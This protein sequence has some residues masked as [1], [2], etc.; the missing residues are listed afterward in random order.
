MRA[1]VV[2]VSALLD[3]DALSPSDLDLTCS[4]LAL[5]FS[6]VGEMKVAVNGI[7]IGKRIVAATLSL[8][9]SE[10][11]SSTHSQQPVT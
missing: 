6:L 4:I 10:E 1:C 5:I 11:G 9:G 2:S 7:M 8:K 3:S